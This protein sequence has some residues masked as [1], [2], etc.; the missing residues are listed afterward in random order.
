MRAFADAA[1]IA[2]IDEPLFK[3]RFNRA[4]DRLMH[5]PVGDCSLMDLPLFWIVYCKALIGMMRI[6]AVH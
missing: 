1:R 4:H 5:N 6:I 3:K 2:I